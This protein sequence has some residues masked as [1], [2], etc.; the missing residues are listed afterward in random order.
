MAKRRRRARKTQEARGTN[1]LLIG[2]VIL[3]GVIGLFAL[4]FLATR[5]PEPE[6]AL[7][8]ADYCSQNENRCVAI[9]EKN[10]PVTFVEV[11]DFGC[12]HCKAFHE[13]KSATIKEDYVDTG[14]VEWI[15]LPYALRSETVPAANA[16]LCANEQGRYFEFTSALFSQPTEVGLT[17]DGFVSAAEEIGLDMEPFSTCLA[18]QRYNQTVGQNQQ[19]AR[20]A[21]VTGTPTFFVNDQM[22]S[23]NV[24]LAEFERLFNQ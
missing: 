21:R 3:I 1:W 13:E 12:P 7:G 6:Q 17:R 18:E 9:G 4:L 8:L 2:G 5:A 16:A 19:A 23:G 24:P 10:A 11:S 15:F 22:V 20:A 14:R